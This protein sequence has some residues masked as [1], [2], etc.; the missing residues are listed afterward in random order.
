MREIA[1]L[2]WLRGA[3]DA[4][5][6]DIRKRAGAKLQDVDQKIERLHQIRRGLTALIDDCPGNGPLRCCSILGALENGA[7]PYIQAEKPEDKDMQTV[8][9]TIKGMHCKG[10]EEIVRNVLERQSGVRGC[11]VSHDNGEARIAFDDDRISA[12]QLATAISEAGYSAEI[13]SV[14]S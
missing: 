10:C 4:D 5:A 9:L 11:S 1:E 13:D 3:R 2:L 14:Q 8:R 12:E 7:T 6:S